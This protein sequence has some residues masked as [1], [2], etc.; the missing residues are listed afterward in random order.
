MAIY[1]NTLS[2]I[3]IKIK[4]M[5]ILFLVS[6]LSCLF[7]SLLAQD[8][9]DFK[10]KS[11]DV[12]LSPT[13]K[14]KMETTTSQL[15]RV[16]NDTPMGYDKDSKPYQLN[17]R[18]IN[19]SDTARTTISQLWKYYALRTIR[20][21]N[22]I[23]D[24]L[25]IDGEEYQ[26]RN[27]KVRRFAQ[28]NPSVCIDTT[29]ISIN[30][31]K[32]GDIVDINTV[33]DKQQYDK[34]IAYAQKIE[35]EFNIKQILYWMDCLR[36][37]YNTKNVQFFEDM[38]SPHALIITGKRTRTRGKKDSNFTMIH[39]NN[40]IY[41]VKDKEQYIKDLKGRIFKNNSY[42]RV[43]FADDAEVWRDGGNS[44]YYAV[45][46][47]QYWNSSTYNDEGRLFV[48]WDFGPKKKNPNAKYP[49]ILYRVWQSPEDAKRF[50]FG[51]FI[52]SNEK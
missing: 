22:T 7:S 16:I 37:A 33:I 24:Q 20:E 46:V 18:H 31:N 51:D 35:D 9:T 10:I 49:Q 3:T 17:L 8:M 25:L 32:N 27:I 11:G 30:Y 29:C 43:E 21:N 38:F 41:T 52:L 42:L 1:S 23:Q 47:T 45:E 28:E 5:K 44:R 15:L 2:K 40:F 36:T 26:V 19:L 14:G 13:I 39:E 6:L 4:Y 50:G 48:I 34:I 12:L